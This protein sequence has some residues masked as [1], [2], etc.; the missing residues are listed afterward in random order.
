[1]PA[2][3]QEM[4]SSI[5]RTLRRFPLR[6]INNTSPNI[7]DVDGFVATNLS[8]G[9]PSVEC[10]ELQVDVEEHVMSSGFGKVLTAPCT[11]YYP[12]YGHGT[13]GCGRRGDLW[14]R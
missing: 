1:M 2:F 8:S 13:E 3:W 14:L 4:G 12:V 6:S 11:G 5:L 7:D 10:R 9:S